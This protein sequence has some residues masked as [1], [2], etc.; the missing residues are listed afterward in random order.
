MGLTLAVD[1]V[2]S[3]GR[4][5]DNANGKNNIG[6]TLLCSFTF[7]PL[8]SFILAEA[9]YLLSSKAKLGNA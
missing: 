8:T 5:D 2:T 6:L 7:F 4:K 9:L 3:P 1:S